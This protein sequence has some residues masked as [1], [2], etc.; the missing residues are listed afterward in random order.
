MA[1]TRTRCLALVASAGVLVGGLLA[2]VTPASAGSAGP[3]AC[4]NTSI[5]TD[6]VHAPS[7][8]LP[9]QAG[10]PAVK[11]VRTAHRGLQV[12]FS[13]TIKPPYQACPNSGSVA[14]SDI[15]CTFKGL[16]VSAR[17][18]M[19]DGSAAQSV[20]G[21]SAEEP[22]VSG[23]C[24]LFTC[25]HVILRMPYEYYG[26]GTLIVNYAVGNIVDGPNGPGALT[27][28]DYENTIAVPVNP[29]PDAAH[30]L[31]GKVVYR[32]KSTTRTIN[33]A[34]K[35]GVP[36]SGVDGVMVYLGGKGSGEIKRGDYFGN[37]E[38]QTEV[39][40][41]TKL[42]LVKQTPSHGTIVVIPIAYYS[43]ASSLSGDLWHNTGPTKV[44]LAKRVSLKHAKVPTDA[45][46][47]LMQI[48]TAHANLTIGGIKLV[49]S[50][51]PQWVLVHAGHGVVTT[52]GGHGAKLA[53]GGYAEPIHLWDEGRTITTS[54]PQS[55]PN[56]MNLAGY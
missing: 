47:V 19:P 38:G 6:C 33:L 22:S 7:S 51:F 55:L 20:G 46:A 12:Q 25:S 8:D 5:N 29:T 48:T 10:P 17:L 35:G 28:S 39:I 23:D 21:D 18:Y 56:L 52:K 40:K 45:N 44:K 30:I 4:S 11:I 1:Q 34:G 9:A 14:Y 26:P 42:H 3:P 49:K 15:P 37:T 32:G 54:Y 24:Q 13:A 2:A 41:G 43:T 36:R 31:K 16:T 53:V 27:S 50:G